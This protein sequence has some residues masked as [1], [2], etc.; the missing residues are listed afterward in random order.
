MSDKTFDELQTVFR[1]KGAAPA[2]DH[3]LQ[4][5]REEKRFH[6]LFDILLMRKRL[7]LGLG[8]VRP[9]S[10]K[11]VPDDRRDEF[12]KTYIDTA[13]HVGEQLLAEGNI[14]QAWHYFRAI[15]EPQAV[16]AA[17]E[18]LPDAGPV[19]DDVVEIALGQG[20]A[21][22]KGMK[23]Y[24]ASH[25][26]CSSI[27]AFDQI[28]PQLTPEVRKQCAQILVRRLYND[29]RDNVQHD[30]QRRQP[31]TPP[32][33]PLRE[34]IGGREWLFADDSYHIDVS[35]LNSIVRFGRFLDDSCPELD[36]VLQLA[37][38]GTRLAQQYQ[39]AGN[40]PF[41]DFYPAHIR[42]FKVLLNI[43][44]DASLEYFRTKIGPD[45]TDSDNQLAAFVLVDLL[46]RI[47]RHN[48]ALE[49]ACQYLADSADEFGISLPELCVKS[50]RLDL[51]QEL[52]RRKDDVVNFAAALLGSRPS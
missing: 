19:A 34:L 49:L 14:A 30:V 41:D 6:Q 13:R 42:F 27:S 12:E 50:G 9:T 16:A 10:L 32:G 5:L 26:T 15:N 29:L 21:P 39:Y 52:A 33:Q 46:Q 51:L 20:V 28:A 18:A 38:Y 31:M 35:H 17:I 7:D 37:Q 45:A 2:L 23:F 11:D 44:R 24:L 22:A 48:E 4:V 8:L 25:G 40:P 43:E 47:G 3:L 36:L 1:E